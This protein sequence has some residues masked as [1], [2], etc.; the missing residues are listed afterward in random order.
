MGNQGIVPTGDEAAGHC[1]A[2]HHCAYG[3]TNYLGPVIYL[4]EKNR[5]PIDRSGHIHT[6]FEDE[7][8]DPKQR[9]TAFWTR[10]YGL[11]LIA[12]TAVFDVY[13]RTELVVIFTMEQ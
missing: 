8:T 12:V 3:E 6:Y 11:N 10:G 7:T 9:N 4:L 2:R 1:Q 5:S 13:E